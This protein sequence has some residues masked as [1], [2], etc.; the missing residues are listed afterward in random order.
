MQTHHPSATCLLVGSAPGRLSLVGS[1]RCPHSKRPRTLFQERG[2]RPPNPPSRP[3]G[4]NSR[5]LRRIQPPPQSTLP[6]QQPANRLP[7]QIAPRLPHFRP[8]WSCLSTFMS[9]SLSF[10]TPRT[11][12][13]RPPIE[14]FPR[15]LYKRPFFHLNS[16]SKSVY[17]QYVHMP[18]GPRPKVS[19]QAATKSRAY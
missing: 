19:N 11:Q 6:T 2:K 9:G 3:R 5:H 12:S 16:F 1:P 7:I 4:K 17:C 13:A 15:K 8:P 18:T 10:L 14:P